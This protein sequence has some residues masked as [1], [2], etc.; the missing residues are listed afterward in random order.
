MY[1]LVT[2]I[3][4]YNDKME[5][6]LN[7]SCWVRPVGHVILI[8]KRVLA[9]HILKTTGLGHSDLEVVVEVASFFL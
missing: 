8:H 1:V 2:F 6:S 5:N 4:D 7:V 9:G 3:L